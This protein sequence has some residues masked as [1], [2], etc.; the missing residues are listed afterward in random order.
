MNF[1]TTVHVCV[2]IPVSKS[3]SNQVSMMLSIKFMASEQPALIK[4][5]NVLTRKAQ[6][7]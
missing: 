1:P 2:N 4:T 3:K 6:L 5:D 7:S